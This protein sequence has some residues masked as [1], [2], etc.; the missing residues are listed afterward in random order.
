MEYSWKLKDYHA[1]NIVFGNI[2]YHAINTIF[3]DIIVVRWEVEWIKFM[4][5]SKVKYE[6][7][8][9]S[10]GSKLKSPVTEMLKGKI[11]LPL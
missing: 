2:D 5:D 8:K 7:Y 11:K 6:E 4:F 10:E 1:I 9:L 3:G